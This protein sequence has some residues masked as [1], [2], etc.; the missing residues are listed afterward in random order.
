MKAVPCFLLVLAVCYCTLSVARADDDD[1]DPTTVKPHKR[2]MRKR[3]AQPTRPPGTLED[4]TLFPANSTL[5]DIDEPWDFD[6][7]FDPEKLSPEFIE[8]YDPGYK[9]GVEN[10]QPK[11]R[12]A[13]K[14]AQPV[15][16]KDQMVRQTCACLA[17]IFRQPTF[18]KATV[19]NHV[20]RYLHEKNVLAYW[21]YFSRVARI[22]FNKRVAAVSTKCYL[23]SLPV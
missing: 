23:Q 22:S 9:P 12:S 20:R 8:K 2:H 6:D 11:L 14:N 7:E 1:D 21:Q 15:C 13:M 5:P 19:M 17:K 10:K 3:I 18:L 4:V 16:L